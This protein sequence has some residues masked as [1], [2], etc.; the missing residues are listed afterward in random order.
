VPPSIGKTCSPDMLLRPDSD[1]AVYTAN[2]EE[3]DH[4]PVASDEN[5]VWEGHGLM[6]WI[7]NDNN[8]TK[9]SVMARLSKPNQERDAYVAEVLLQLHP[10]RAIFI[11]F[12]IGPCIA[13]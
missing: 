11:F 9:T 1:S 8:H 7:L 2:F 10:V 5:I 12:L 4:K 6:S 3:I 13:C